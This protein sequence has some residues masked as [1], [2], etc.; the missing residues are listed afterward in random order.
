M[1]FMV[2]HDDTVSADGRAHCMAACQNVVVRLAVT[3]PAPR[4]SVQIKN[5]IWNLT[6]TAATVFPKKKIRSLVESVLNLA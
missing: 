5:G 6:I 4:G 2:T 1:S 3:V